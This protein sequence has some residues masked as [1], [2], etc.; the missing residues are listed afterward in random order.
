MGHE[1]CVGT[2]LTGA[3]LKLKLLRRAA[4][5]AHY[6]AL[7]NIARALREGA[8]QREHSRSYGPTLPVVLRH[9]RSRT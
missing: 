8:E 1:T 3:D 4:I 2:Q 5:V 9:S 6:T 7:A